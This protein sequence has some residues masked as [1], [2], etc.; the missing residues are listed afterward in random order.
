MTVTEQIL[1][2][3]LSDKA[4]I[5][6]TY[7]DNNAFCTVV[8]ENSSLLYLLSTTVVSKYNIIA[9]IDP[10]LTCTIY[11]RDKANLFVDWSHEHYGNKGNIEDLP[12]EQIAW[13]ISNYLELDTIQALK[14]SYKNNSTDFDTVLYKFEEKDHLHILDM[15]RQQ[16]FIDTNGLWTTEFL[17]AYTQMQ[18][19]HFEEAQYSFC[20]LNATKKHYDICTRRED[21]KYNI[22][23]KNGSI[24]KIRK[25][26]NERQDTIVVF[27]NQRPKV[28]EQENKI[29]NVVLRDINDSSYTVAN[30]F[31]RLQYKTEQLLD[32]Q[33]QR[34]TELK[35]SIDLS[36]VTYPDIEVYAEEIAKQLRKYKKVEEDSV[37]EE[38]IQHL[39]ELYTNAFI[40]LDKAKACIKALSEV[41]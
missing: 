10:K 16:G 29:K 17:L 26:F 6:Q 23:S 8:D 36:K 12:D 1:E 38:I 39:T 5:V 37:K 11:N 14:F 35:G 24:G 28:R 13:Y 31:I 2:L 4:K 25:R 34:I 22:I 18:A 30:R 40:E 33:I 9:T 32:E 7:G 3:Q 20:K 19:D 21:G 41:A 15:L 27:F